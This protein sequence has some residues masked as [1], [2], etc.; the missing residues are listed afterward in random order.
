MLEA[1][2]IEEIS[3][4]QGRSK[5]FPPGQRKRGPVPVENSVQNE[6]RLDREE[7]RA[8]TPQRFARSEGKQDLCGHQLQ[9]VVSKASKRPVTAH[10]FRGQ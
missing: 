9:L 6:M 7:V 1:P 5:S 4:C 8:Q 2:T 3:N 10:V